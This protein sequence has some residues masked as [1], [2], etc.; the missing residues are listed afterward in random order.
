[1]GL[2]ISITRTLLTLNRE[3]L[4]HDLTL[5]SIVARRI[6]LLPRE[7]TRVIWSHQHGSCS[8]NSGL[9]IDDVK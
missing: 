4:I 7:R 5:S 8:A 6:S 1:V 2:K 9:Q 3:L